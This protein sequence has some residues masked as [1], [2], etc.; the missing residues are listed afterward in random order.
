LQIQVKCCPNAD[1]CTNFSFFPTC[2]TEDSKQQKKSRI[3]AEH[4]LN[5]AFEANDIIDLLEMQ[6]SISAVLADST[7][8]KDLGGL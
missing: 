7:L 6:Q 5:T 8:L 4:H 1:G 3:N 2:A